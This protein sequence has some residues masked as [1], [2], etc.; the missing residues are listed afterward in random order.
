MRI[1]TLDG[2]EVVWNLRGYERTADDDTGSGPHRRAR[3]VLREAFPFDRVL[4]EVPIPGTKLRADFLVP[5]K[6]VIVEVQGRQHYEHSARLHGSY[7]NYLRAR[8]RDRRKVQFC[9]L[10]DIRLIELRDDLD[11]DEWRR[12]LRG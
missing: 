12:I 3:S 5:S 11:D 1:K 2:R 10:N 8:R 4:E 7:E 9:D 6:M